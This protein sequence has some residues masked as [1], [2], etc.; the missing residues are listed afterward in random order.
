MVPYFCNCSLSHRVALLRR[1]ANRSADSGVQVGKFF[2]PDAAHTLHGVSIH[3]TVALRHAGR[4]IHT[5]V[6]RGMRPG[7]LGQVFDSATEPGVALDQQNITR[8]QN[9]LQVQ[10]VRGR[11]RAIDLKLFAQVG[12]QP[13]ANRLR[14]SVHT[15]SLR[16]LGPS[17]VMCALPLST[18]RHKIL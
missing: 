3:Q 5:H 10:G 14:Q 9:G 13:F 17:S 2:Q 11:C 18:G 7:G 6:K 12:R 15:V 8:L 1:Q 4:S 16:L